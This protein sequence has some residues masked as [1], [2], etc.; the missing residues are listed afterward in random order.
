MQMQLFGPLITKSATLSPSTK[1]Q[2]KNLEKGKVDR[3]CKGVKE[4]YEEPITCE[5]AFSSKIVH[6]VQLANCKKKKK[7]FFLRIENMSGW[8]F[9]FACF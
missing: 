6:V 7:Q 1:V 5:K 4:M 9:L 3:E 2:I 8:G